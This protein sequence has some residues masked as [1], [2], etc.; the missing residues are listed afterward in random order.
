MILIDTSVW[1]A[2]LRANDDVLVGLLDGG[3]TLEHFLDFAG[4]DVLAT[5]DE[6]VVAPADK[7]S[8]P[9]E[10]KASGHCSYHPEDRRI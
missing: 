8:D 3:M 1:V 7:V 10:G 6:H 4:E 5:G 2:H 9:M